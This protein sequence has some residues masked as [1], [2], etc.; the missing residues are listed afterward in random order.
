M[1]Q[2]APTKTVNKLNIKINKKDV[3]KKVVQSLM[4][5]F[6]FFLLGLLLSYLFPEEKIISENLRLPLQKKVMAS[7]GDYI[8]ENEQISKYIGENYQ[9]IDG[10][11][12][13]SWNDLNKN[14][15]NLEPGDIFFTSSGKYLSS[16]FIP[17]KWKHSAIYLGSKN[18]LIEFFGE[19]SEIFKNFSFYYKDDKQILVIDSSSDGVQI[20]EIKE[21]SNISESSYLKS[22]VAF[23]INKDKEQIINFLNKSKNQ[24]GKEYDYDLITEN[25]QELYC[26]ELIYHSLEEIGFKINKEKSYAREMV[27]PDNLVDYMIK[28][29]NFSFIIFLEKQNGKIKKL[30]KSYIIK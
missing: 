4:F 8:I 12:N 14:L 6:V 9:V 17:G 3:V 27:S 20:R 10:Q 24:I 22:F 13:I 16:L 2:N 1:G 28:D 19:E 15:P 23:R 30:T 29:E 7:V 25:D 5:I 26:S 21:L 18:Q 11:N